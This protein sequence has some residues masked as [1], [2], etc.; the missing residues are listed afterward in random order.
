MED[1]EEMANLTRINLKL[2][3]SLTQA[4][5]KILVLSKQLQTLQV[6]TKTKTPD[7]KRTALYKKTKDDK[8]KCYCWTRGRNRRLD[9]TRSTCNFP[10]TGQQVVATFG[11]KMGRIEKWYEDK[12]SHE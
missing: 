7:K 5:E 6:Q 1:K 9:H 2:S 8:L 10:K 11:N 3:H 4:Q 12:K